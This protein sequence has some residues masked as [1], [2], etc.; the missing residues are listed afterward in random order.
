MSVLHVIRI[1][2][3]SRELS[4]SIEHCIYQSFSKYL[5]NFIVVLYYEA[6]MMPMRKY[7]SHLCSK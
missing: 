5:E 2:K 3:Y 1:C 7:F 4:I 6:F